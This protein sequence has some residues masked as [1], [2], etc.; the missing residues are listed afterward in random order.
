MSR[1]KEIKIIMY[2]PL[3]DKIEKFQTNVNK[4]FVDMI[5]KEFKRGN[6]AEEEIEII[7]KR[8]TEKF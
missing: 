5:K 4:I 1:K 2:P 8:L 7:T 3:P 6:Y